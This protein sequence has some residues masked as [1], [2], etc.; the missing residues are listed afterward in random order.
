MTNIAKFLPAVA[1]GV[2][3]L[4]QP[5]IA[6]E[7]GEPVAVR[8]A[9]LNLTSE[10]GRRELDR[11]LEAAVRKTCG[12]DEKVTGSRIASREARK[13]YA[14]TRAQLDQRFAAIVSKSQAGG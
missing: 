2:L 12:M 7:N 3:A 4:S 1:L 13:C 10:E 9:D 5:A 6:A 11:R 14:E 8:Y